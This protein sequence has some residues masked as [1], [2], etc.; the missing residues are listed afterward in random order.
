MQKQTKLDVCSSSNSGEGQKIHLMNNSIAQKNESNKTSQMVVEQNCDHV[1]FCVVVFFGCSLQTQSHLSQKVCK[2]LCPSCQVST[3]LPLLFGCLSS[4]SS[5]G[6]SSETESLPSTT[7]L[8]SKNNRLGWGNKVSDWVSCYSYSFFVV[9]YIRSWHSMSQGMRLKRLKRSISFSQN[10]AKRGL[11]KTRFLEICRSALR[12]DTLD[13]LN[14]KRPL[15][16]TCGLAAFWPKI[17][18]TIQNWCSSIIW[19]KQVVHGLCRLAFHLQLALTCP[20][21]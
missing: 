20:C 15:E 4:T 5:G 14:L 16:G 9:D 2:T 13:I 17:L 6:G 11:L 19:M 1:L 10:C 18:K 3:L 21:R 12:H 8:D 7:F